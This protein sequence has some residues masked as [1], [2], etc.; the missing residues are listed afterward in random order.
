MIFF[1][2]IIILAILAFSAQADGKKIERQD[3][4][5][6]IGVTVGTFVLIAVG[7]AIQILF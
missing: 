6:A 5:V 3:I 7:R 2:I 1:L 4:S